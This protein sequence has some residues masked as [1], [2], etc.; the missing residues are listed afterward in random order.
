M[1]CRSCSSALPVESSI[2]TG[3][4]RSL[5]SA[6]AVPVVSSRNGACRFPEAPPDDL[7]V[8]HSRSCARKTP[9]PT[10]HPRIIERIV[11]MR[12]SPPEHFQRVPGPKALLYYLPR[13]AQLQALGAPLPRS[14]RTIWKILRPQGCILEEPTRRQKLSPREPL[15]EVQMDFKD[16]ST[17]PAAAEGQQQHVVEVL[18]LVDAGTSILLNAQVHQDFH[19][20]TAFEAVVQFLRKYG[21]PAML[22]F[23]RD[24]RWVG[25]ASRR[26]F[27]SALR[28][29]LLCL[30]SEPNVCPREP[31]RQE[32]VW[33]EIS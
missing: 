7:A 12:E 33:G 10:V 11:Q 9:P 23:D 8:L 1:D 28:R 13:D 18:N 14:T 25:S 31:T 5:L 16:A 27:P 19:A 20:E 30:D 32:S 17:V 4:S 6:L 3:H 29:F 22:T 21:L 2:L 24:S 26:D 15:E